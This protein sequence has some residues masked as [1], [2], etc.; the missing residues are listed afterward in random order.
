MLLLCQTTYAQN[1]TQSKRNDSLFKTT[2]SINFSEPILKVISKNTGIDSNLN[3]KAP[4][5]YIGKQ[6]PK[7]LYRMGARVSMKNKSNESDLFTDKRKE[8]YN[9]YDL[10]ISGLRMKSISNK[11]KL[12]YGLMA[13]SFVLFDKKIFDSG[14]D[15]VTFSNRTWSVAAGPNFLL[16]YQINKR[17]SV[18]TEYVLAYQFSSS[19]TGKEFSA[20]PEE[21][22]ANDIS[23]QHGLQIDYPISLYI[24]YHF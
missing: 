15:K 19:Y 18:F 7:I 22:Y 17:L 13:S 6:R 10:S 11:L 2:I 23:R 9:K 14:F 16:Q 8:Q 3:L 20:F 12:G 4:F 24:T 1:Q 5:I 21:N